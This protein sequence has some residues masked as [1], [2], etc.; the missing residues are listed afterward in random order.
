MGA[1]VDGGMQGDRQQTHTERE[2][3]VEWA[4]RKGQVLRDKQ[5]V[6]DKAM[7]AGGVLLS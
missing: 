1:S 3:R 2:S 6:K 4:N 7:R 5:I